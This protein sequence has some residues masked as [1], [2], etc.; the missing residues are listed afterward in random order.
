[1]I[2]ALKRCR[3]GEREQVAS[4]LKNAAQ[5]ADEHGGMAPLEAPELEFASVAEI[6]ERYHGLRDTVARAH[7]NVEKALEA[8]APFPENLAAAF[9]AVLAGPSGK[10][11]IASRA[12]ST[13]S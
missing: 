3:V 9:K 13:F 4:V 11:A 8:I 5:L 2:L 7:E 6:V 10:G 1:M 12:F